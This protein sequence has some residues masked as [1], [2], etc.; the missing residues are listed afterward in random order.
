MTTKSP[1]FTLPPR[2]RTPRPGTQRSPPALRRRASSGPPPRSSPPL[3]REVAVE[4]R[5]R[6]FLAVGVPQRPDDRL[7]L[8]P[9]PRQILPRVFSRDGD[10]VRF[11]EPR[12]LEQLREDRRSPA[13]S[14]SSI[15]Y[16]EGDNLAQRRR[17]PGDGVDAR[18]TARHSR[19]C[20]T[21]STWRI[22]FVEPPIAMSS[23]SALPKAARVVMSRSLMS[24]RIVLPSAGTTPRDRI[25][26]VSC[27]PPARSGAP[28]ERHP[29]PFR[30]G[31]RGVPP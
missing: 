11:H 4:D 19:S 30:K 12:H 17:R 26:R 16:Q 5:E 2:I 24:F 15:V 28:G 23:A 8:R 18:Q 6:P 21:A 9:R 14:T 29:E 3:R 1:A 31:S 25:R 10:A 7:V 20:A 22:V 13:R 27:R